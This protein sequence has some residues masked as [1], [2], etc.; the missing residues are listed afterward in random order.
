MRLFSEK[1][2]ICVGFVK[3]VQ[4][5]WLLLRVLL[6][7]NQCGDLCT[8]DCF[9]KPNSLIMKKQFLS[10]KTLMLTAFIFVISGCAITIKHTFDQPPVV[11]N[12]YYQGGGGSGNPDFVNAENNTLSTEGL[13]VGYDIVWTD[14][15][16]WT[17]NSVQG[18][19]VRPSVF[20]F[21]SVAD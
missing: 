19:G 3:Y 9:T 4:R 6:W 18:V 11:V 2:E 15:E 13:G 20:T 21:W 12:N 14:P 5:L 16:N 8:I 10:A 17:K 7:S 1:S